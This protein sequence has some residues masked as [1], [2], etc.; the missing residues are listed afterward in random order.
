M[1]KMACSRGVFVLVLMCY[2]TVSNA[3]ESDFERGFNLMYK[4][5]KNCE[6]S[7]DVVPCLKVKAL[8]LADRALKINTIPIFDGLNVVRNEEADARSMG[9]AEFDENALPVNAQEKENTLDNMIVDRVSRFL[10]THSL[11]FS[12]PA[13]LGIP[14]DATQEGKYFKNGESG[15]L[16]R[17]Y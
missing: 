11:Q 5:Y 14:E 6:A 12:L 13:M 1:C 3:Q 7:G 2:Y 8:K 16:C 15:N 10:K 17:F 4:T 9:V